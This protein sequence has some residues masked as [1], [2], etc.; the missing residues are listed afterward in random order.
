MFPFLYPALRADC[1]HGVTQCGQSRSSWIV[2]HQAV[3]LE[4]EV[5][6]GGLQRPSS[7]FLR[8]LP[9]R[10]NVTLVLQYLTW[11]INQLWVL[12][13]VFSGFRPCPRSN[14]EKWGAQG[15]RFFPVQWHL[16]TN[17]FPIPFLRGGGGLGWDT[18]EHHKTTNLNHQS[19]GS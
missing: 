15:D 18:M 4:G 17:A 1:D 9:D 12:Q 11:D 3:T 19:E 14:Q 7:R 16:C 13:A 8:R 5:V 6:R 2:V 10:Q